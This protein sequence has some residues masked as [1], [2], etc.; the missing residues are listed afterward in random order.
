MMCVAAGPQAAIVKLEQKLLADGIA[1]RQLQTTHAFHSKMMEEIL[2]EFKQLVSTITLH[3]PKIPYV[4]NVTGTWIKPE[5]AIDSEYWASHLRQP[6]R[7]ADGI[8]TLWKKPDN[9]LLE[10]GFGQT[11]GSLALQHPTIRDLSDPLVLS[12]LPTTYD[13]QTDFALMLRSLGQ[14]W[15]TGIEINWS[16]FYAKEQRKRRPLPTYPF[17]HQNYWVDY[18]TSGFTTASKS[19]EDSGQ[20]NDLSDWF[21]APTWKRLPLLEKPRSSKSS[22]LFFIK[23]TGLS[24]IEKIQARGEPVTIVKIGDSFSRVNDNTY[25]I[26]PQSSEDYT[27]LL[28]HL[29]QINQ[30]PNQ[31]VHL[32]SITETESEHPS[33]ELGRDSFYSLVFLAQAL[34]KQRE[35]MAT[36]ISVISNSM[37][38]VLGNELLYPETATLLGPCKIIPKEYDSISCTSID[39]TLPLKTEALV[40]ELLADNSEETIAYRENNRWVQAFEPIQLKET[41]LERLKEKGVY[42]LTGGLG[43]LGFALS[44]SLAKK[45]SPKLVLLSRNPNQTEKVAELEKLGAEVLV[46]AAN[47]ANQLDME[48]AITE[49]HKRFGKINGVFHLAGV[50]GEGVIQSKTVEMADAVLS[51]KLQGTIV[52]DKV[53]R[54]EKLDFMVLYSSINSIIGGM[55]EVDYCAANAFMDAYANYNTTQHAIPTYAIN[56]GAWEWDVWQSALLDSLPEIYERMKEMRKI[57]GISFDEGEEALWRI[58]AT[59]L[60]QV[61]VLTQGLETAISQWESLT[62]VNFLEKLS[63]QDSKNKSIFPRPNLRTAYVAPNDAIEQKIAD[64]WANSLALEK[65]GVQDQFFELGGNSLIGMMIISRLEKEFDTKLSAATL[66]EG[67]TVR[68]LSKMIQPKEEKEESLSQY[69]ERGKKRSK[70]QRRKGLKKFD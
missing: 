70:R 8:E 40:T 39:V 16:S 36:H 66:Y 44:K 51:P 48:N 24:L 29:Y 67:P 30:P 12:S 2:V 14:L 53:L 4:S 46:I 52:L 64:I 26:N 41:G 17:E 25:T 21:Y 49:T 28:K 62:S 13:Q 43:G 5:Q 15:L 7:F 20:K 58:L 60:P 63:L 23:K 65:V 33:V 59:P 68:T 37:Q 35:N 38:N 19:K 55:G 18:N 11:L 34:G 56:W 57:Y 31:I 9:I 32:W 3:K 22:W 47:V 27:A 45:F 6:V 61:L 54:D 1:A 69:S 50:P 10:V 42:L